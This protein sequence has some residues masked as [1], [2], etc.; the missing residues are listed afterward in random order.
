MLF[1]VIILL[2]TIT[3]NNHY[4]ESRDTNILPWLCYVVI[5]RLF[6]I[7]YW[8][9]AIYLSWRYDNKAT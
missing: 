3:A 2:G 4:F 8:I 6:D 7:F 9:L 5:T 1:L